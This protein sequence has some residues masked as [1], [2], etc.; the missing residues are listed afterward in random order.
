MKTFLQMFQT[1]FKHKTRCK[2]LEEVISVD[3]P[4]KDVEL[5]IYCAD[6]YHIYL[7][8]YEMG[9]K[10][11]T[12]WAQ[13]AKTL[14]KYILKHYYT[15]HVPFPGILFGWTKS[16]LLWILYLS[17]TSLSYEE[18]PELS[19]FDI[20]YA[21]EAGFRMFKDD[22]NWGQDTIMDVLEVL[23]LQWHSIDL[24]EMK[25][26]LNVLWYR[27]AKLTLFTHRNLPLTKFTDSNR[28]NTKCI[29]ACLSRFY[30]FE[31][32]MTVRIHHVQPPDGIM[33]LMKW[34]EREKQYLVSSKFRESVLQFV[35]KHIILPGD[36]EIETADD[37]EEIMSLYS[38]LNRRMPPGLL[39]HYQKIITYST[40][41]DII[42]TCLKPY[43]VLNL[44]NEKITNVYNIDWFKHFYCQDIYKHQNI[45]N[46]IQVPLVCYWNKT[47]CVFCHKKKR[48][49]KAVDAGHAFLH[50]LSLVKQMGFVCYDSY[51]FKPIYDEI[52][53]PEEEEKEVEEVVNSSFVEV[54]VF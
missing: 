6:L 38:C 5:F 51:N 1:K 21:N 41:E 32:S 18:P 19:I 47:F 24:K 13:V 52:F 14:K 20:T 15:L 48:L 2:T 11:C 29:I 54:D 23:S 9:E 27:V 16:M 3:I 53:P 26:F 34:V 35:W 50:W 40:F 31:K 39:N 4:E 30:Y 44:I 42:K 8:S 37:L 12:V 33:M 49:Y 36:M 17:A 22:D 46:D 25:N 28:I 10:K 45:L 7:N 43:L